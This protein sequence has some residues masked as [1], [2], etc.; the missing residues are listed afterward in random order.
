MGSTHLTGI[1]SIHS[2]LNPQRQHI[3]VGRVALQGEMLRVPVHCECPLVSVHLGS[4]EELHVLRMNVL[5]LLQPAREVLS[6]LPGGK[7]WIQHAAGLAVVT[8]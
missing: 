1:I 6:F 2:L 3:A 5:S 4:S 7:P 8:W